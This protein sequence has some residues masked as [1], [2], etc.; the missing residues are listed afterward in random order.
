MHTFFCKHGG[1]SMFAWRDFPDGR[2]DGIRFPTL[3][4]LDID[5]LA[6]APVKFEDGRIDRFNRAPDDIRLL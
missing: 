2:Y 4:D 1:T 5:E 3:D 6:A